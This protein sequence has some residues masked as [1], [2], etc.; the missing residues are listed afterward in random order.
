MTEELPPGTDPLDL[1]SG[2]PSV[3][4]SSNRT[5][6]SFERT[7]MSADRT[8]MSVIRT[9]LSLISF[10]FTISQFLAKM[11]PRF[12]GAIGE[13]QARN[14]GLALVALGLMVLVAGLF[15][16]MGLITSLRDRRER[17]LGLKLV[18]HGP[19]FRNSPTAI[20]AVLLL[21]IGLAAVF[22]IVARVGPFA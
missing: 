13:H 14:F 4:L 15:S 11:A 1:I 18:H 5:V 20:A 17:L 6:L 9:S 12:H 3:E 21:L 8:L 16:H 22:A 7:R 10:G 2:S 19:Q